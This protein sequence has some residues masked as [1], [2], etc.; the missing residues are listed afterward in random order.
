MSIIMV[1]I[2]TTV[3]VKYFFKWFAWNDDYYYSIG[4][5]ITKD[6]IYF[7]END[8]CNEEPKLFDII[9][10]TSKQRKLIKKYLFSYQDICKNTTQYHYISLDHF[11]YNLI[12]HYNNKLLNKLVIGDSA[13]LKLQRI[14]FKILSDQKVK[15]S[16]YITYI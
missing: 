2:N 13:S 10:I 1:P 9:P 11:L 6:S 4:F 15:Y 14:I 16:D 5:A 8:N 3:D 12:G 7:Y